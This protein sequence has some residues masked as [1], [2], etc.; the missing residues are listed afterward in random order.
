MARTEALD[1]IANNLA[2]SSTGGF[3]ARH[4]SYA[5]LQAGFG[6]T[7]GSSLNQATNQFGLLGNSHLDLL[8]GPLQPTGNS[9][10]VGIDG[11]GF[12]TIQSAHGLAYTRNGAMKVTPDGQLVTAAGEPVIGTSGPI[13][14][15]IGATVNI[16]TDG[17]ITA[18]GA[19]AGQLKLVQFVPGADPQSQGATNY[20]VP[21]NQVEDSPTSQVRQGMLEGSNVNPVSGVI[22]LIDAQRAAEGMRHALS[23]ID[24]ELNKTAA[25]DLPRIS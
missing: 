5:S 16:S 2:N 24:S 1:T 8:T 4:T 25:Q 14:I 7:L 6:Q 20:L 19:V 18:N 17:T 13:T 9:L 12:L 22:E 11:P 23:M 3:R 15:P 10:D 21:A